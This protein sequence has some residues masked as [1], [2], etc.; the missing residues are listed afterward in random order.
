MRKWY[1]GPRGRGGPFKQV[2]HPLVPMKRTEILD[3]YNQHVKHCPSCSKV[4]V[5]AATS[6][7]GC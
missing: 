2:D 4:G 5:C 7:N 3:R 1:H 6:S